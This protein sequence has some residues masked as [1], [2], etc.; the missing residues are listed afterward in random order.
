MRKNKYFPQFIDEKVNKK[1][2]LCWISNLGI[3]H[4]E[5]SSSLLICLCG[6][7]NLNINKALGDADA[8]GLVFWVVCSWGK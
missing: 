8:V 2:K 6:P 4:V 3:Q 7:K 5:H 1:E